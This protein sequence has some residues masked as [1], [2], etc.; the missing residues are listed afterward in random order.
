M[1][2]RQYNRW[3]SMYKK[4][5]HT[6]DLC[7]DFFFQRTFTAKIFLLFLGKLCQQFPF[8]QDMIICILAMRD[9]TKAAILRAIFRI[10]EITPASITQ[11]IQRTIAEKAIKIF[12]VCYS[13][14]WKIFT[15]L[16]AKEFVFTH[17]CLYFFRKLIIM[18]GFRNSVLRCF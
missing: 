9:H 7:G 17:G 11:R 18:S 16:I 12:L 14:A 4:N 5:R 13:M 1:L 2:N 8:M 3:Y 6:Y 15:F 10:A